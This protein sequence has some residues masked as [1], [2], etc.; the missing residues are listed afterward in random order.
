VCASIAFPHSDDFP[1]FTFLN[2]VF[3][4]LLLD[5]FFSSLHR[6]TSFPSSFPP[7][8]GLFV[9]FSSSHFLL[10]SSLNDFL[11]F[12]LLPTTK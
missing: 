10:F 1:I 6:T 7:I 11:L 5:L 9:I 3:L 2:S 12:F 4:S 8:Y